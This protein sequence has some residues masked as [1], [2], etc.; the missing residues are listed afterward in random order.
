MHK[1]VHTEQKPYKCEICNKYFKRIQYLKDHIKIHSGERPLEMP[2]KCD[3]C[4]KCYIKPNILKTIKELI[5]EK[6]H[7]FASSV[8][9]VLDVMVN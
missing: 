4:D 9:N 8:I 3:Y 2:H 6:S 7:I 5:Q 1:K